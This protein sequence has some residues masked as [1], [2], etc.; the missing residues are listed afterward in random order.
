M[1]IREGIRRIGL[2]LGV[3]G[4]A[5][6]SVVAVLELSATWNNSTRAERWRVATLEGRTAN[7]PQDYSGDWV[8]LSRP[9]KLGDVFTN[10]SQPTRASKPISDA[11]VIEES[12]YS[13]PEPPSIGEWIRPLLWPLAGFLLPWGLLRVLG[14]IVAGFAGSR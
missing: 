4:G 10:G 5:L 1:N 13:E 7:I 11:P 2:A 9:P 12:F 8:I 3:L 14:W 6:G